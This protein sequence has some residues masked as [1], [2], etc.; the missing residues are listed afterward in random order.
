MKF[1]NYKFGQMTFKSYFKAAGQGYEVGVTYQGKNVF[2]GNFVHLTEA[3][4]WWT[5]MHKHM[6]SFVAQHEFV[7]TASTGWY[8]K[9]LGNF[10]YKPYYGWLD[11][12]FAKYQKSYSKDFFRDNRKYKMLEKNYFLKVG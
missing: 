7:P 8:L 5:L 4:Q 2:V 11:K 12:T 1:K 6:R 10:L 3:R 9:F